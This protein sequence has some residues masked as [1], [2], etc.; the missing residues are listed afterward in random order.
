MTLD[1]E[2]DRKIQRDQVVEL[3]GK[4]LAEAWLREQ[5]LQQLKKQ[6]STRIESAPRGSDDLM[7][8]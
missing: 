1:G 8:D 5:L 3:L 6:T 7:A 4:L 2:N